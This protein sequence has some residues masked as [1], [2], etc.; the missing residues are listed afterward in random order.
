M[1]NLHIRSISTFELTQ[2]RDLQLQ[3]YRSRRLFGVWRSDWYQNEARELYF[4]FYK[5]VFGLV[6]FVGS[7]NSIVMTHA[8]LTSSK[9]NLNS[10]SDPPRIYR[11]CWIKT[12]KFKISPSASFHLRNHSQSSYCPNM[13]EFGTIWSVH[14]P[15]PT[16]PPQKL[17]IETLTPGL[18][19]IDFYKVRMLHPGQQLSVIG[20]QLI[21]NRGFSAFPFKYPKKCNVFRKLVLRAQ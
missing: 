16:I 10:Q 6:Q 20:K 9:M 4:L 17:G 1:T 2:N 18:K 12:T 7:E 14:F 8:R 11:K 21:Q 5:T 13:S 15:Y 3:V 19:L